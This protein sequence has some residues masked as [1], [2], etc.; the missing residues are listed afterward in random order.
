MPVTT[1]SHT[2]QVL[3]ND[4]ARLYVQTRASVVRMYW[5][6]GKRIVEVEQGGA[7]RAAYGGRL[8]PRLSADLTERF[9]VG[10]SRRHLQRMRGRYLQHKIT[11]TSAQLDWS[12]Q[13]ALLSLP[14]AR[15]RQQLAARVQEQGLSAQAL[16]ALVRDAREHLAPDPSTRATASGRGLAQDS[17]PRAE[18]EVPRA[19]PV[20]LHEP[21]ASSE[22][23]Q[24]RR[25]GSRCLSPNV[26]H[27]ACSRSGRLPRHA[28]SI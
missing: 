1:R 6:I 4:I 23:T 2:Y 8:L 27:W 19:M 17:A 16:R 14:D 20:G 22:T 9:G 24:P 28:A 3:L 21:T 5:E 13:V 15:W 7:D 11:P 25:E 18:A 26:A 10:F 12:H